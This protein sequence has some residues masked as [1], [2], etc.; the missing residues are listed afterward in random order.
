[1]VA[2]YLCVDGI[3]LSN[4]RTVSYL[5]NGYNAGGVQWRSCNCCS[6]DFYLVDNGG[7][8]Y[9]D[10][11]TDEMPWVSPTEPESADWAGIVITGI[12]GLDVHGSVREVIDRINDGGQFGRQRRGPREIVV[13]AISVGRTCTAAWWGVR[14]L[15]EQLREPLC[16]TSCGGVDVSFYLNCPDF[17]GSCL[18]PNDIVSITAAMAPY[19]RTLHNVALTNGITVTDRLNLSRCSCQNGECSLPV[20]EFTLTAGDPYA[21]TEPSVTT[22]DGIVFPCAG[23]GTCPTWYV[24]PD[25]EAPIDPCAETPACAGDPVC[26]SIPVPPDPPLLRDPCVC[27]PLTLTTT[28][29]DMDADLFS[30]MGQT[31]PYFTIKAGADPIRG[32]AVR[33]IPRDGNNLSACDTC[34]EINLP[35]LP[36]NAT[37]TFDA[38]RRETTITC[39]GQTNSATV[40]GE[41]GGPLIW[42]VFECVPTNYAMCVTVGCGTDISGLRVNAS[43]IT[44]HG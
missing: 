6:D 3:E 17:K 32:L 36:A 19:K 42:P 27:D 24:V 15:N 25:G 39:G 43:V 21:Y 37:W 12:D 10:P 22:T 29:F 44:R 16:S 23:S 11:T 18:I 35:F 4:C 20:I 33:F 26:G 34:F 13:S 41:D 1:M 14:W 28:C 31:V 40:T 38:S 9:T 7:D 8:P 5:Q 2:N 30:D